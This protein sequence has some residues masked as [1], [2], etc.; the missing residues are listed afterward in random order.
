MAVCRKT[1]IPA[2]RG[3]TRMIIERYTWKFHVGIKRDRRHFQSAVQSGSNRPLLTG[4]L[5]LRAIPE[6]DLASEGVAVCQ[7]FLFPPR[8]EIFGKGGRIG[9]IDSPKIFNHDLPH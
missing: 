3:E 6:M 4:S 8:A 1:G 5:A 2:I 7:A 9:R